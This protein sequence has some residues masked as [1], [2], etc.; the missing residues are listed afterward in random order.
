ME[1]VLHGKLVATPSPA[2]VPMT[3]CVMIDFERHSASRRW[4]FEM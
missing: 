3:T 4:M 1:Q 2:I